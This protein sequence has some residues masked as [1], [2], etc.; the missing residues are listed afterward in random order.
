VWSMEC[1]WIVEEI[2]QLIHF[3]GPTP[4]EEVPVWLILDGFYDAIV[5]AT[6]VDYGRPDIL[7]V[8]QVRDS[9]LNRRLRGWP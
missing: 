6:G 1:G 9:I 8:A 4:W 2:A 3:V 5:G 7:R